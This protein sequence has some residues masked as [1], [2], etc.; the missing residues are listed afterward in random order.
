M[1]R[2]SMA[3]CG[4]VGHSSDYCKPLQ[5]NIRLGILDQFELIF[6]LRMVT[7]IEQEKILV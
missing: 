5:L 6:F 3:V 1:D 2:K 7:Q 4:V